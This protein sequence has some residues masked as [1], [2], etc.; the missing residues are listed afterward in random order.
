MTTAATLAAS[1]PDASASA[2]QYLTFKLAGEEYGVD[3]LRVQEIKGW[4]Q[5]T[6]IPQAPPFVIGVI[7]LRGA[8]VPI[9][10]LRRRL[11]LATV[12]IGPTTVVIVVRVAGERGERTVGVVVDAVC[13]VYT[14]ATSQLQ[15]APDV[16]A[17]VDTAF[18]RGL[19]TVASKLVILLDMDR[20][21]NAS[22]F[23]GLGA[24]A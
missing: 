3:I 2:G 16:G 11:G 21:V 13:D 4:E 9:I 18:I 24:A 8:I 15:P 19:A 17:G 22:I 12:A 10:E 14:V 5:A 7:N 20:L 23:D 1:G 6:R